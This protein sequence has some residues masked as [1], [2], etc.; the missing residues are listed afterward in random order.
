MMAAKVTPRNEAVPFVPLTPRT[1][2]RILRL[3]WRGEEWELT[4]SNKCRRFSTIEDVAAFLRELRRRKRAGALCA[5]LEE[6]DEKGRW[7][8]VPELAR[9]WADSGFPEIDR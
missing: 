5:R 7:R 6:Q 8:D 9:L 1:N 2:R 3:R 4:T